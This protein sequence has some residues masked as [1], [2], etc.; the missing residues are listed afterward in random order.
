MSNAKYI[1]HENGRLK[2]QESTS[3]SQG[4]LSAGAIPALGTDGRLDLSLM[5]TG[6][7]PDTL[8]A[9][10]SDNLSGGMLVNVWDDNG[11]ASFRRADASI[12]GKEA[13]GFVLES[14]SIGETVMCYFEG[15]NTALTDL[16]VGKRYYLSAIDAG[17]VSDVVPTESGNVVQYIGR[18]IS[19]TAL[20]F[21]ATD[22][23]ILA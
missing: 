18:A 19:T 3:I 6:I 14:A 22:G 9:V 20:S 8:V 5:P 23:I 17:K 15:R 2:E 11:V 16:I 4:A 10:A 13:D 21:E 12:A 1:K 7:A